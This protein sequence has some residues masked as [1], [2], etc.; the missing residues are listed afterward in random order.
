MKPTPILLLAGDTGWLPLLGAA[1]SNDA[2]GMPG[3]A[4]LGG[5]LDEGGFLPDA[6]AV[7]AALRDP[8]SVG[9]SLG[10]SVSV[11]IGLA[12]HRCFASSVS[13]SGLPTRQL[14]QT[15]AYRFE[16][17]VPFAVEDLVLDVHGR[18]DDRLVV[19]AHFQ[20]LQALVH[21]LEDAGVRVCGI[22][23]FALLA[24][25]S[26]DLDGSQDDNVSPI[27][28]H[29]LSEP[30]VLCTAKVRSTS[31]VALSRDGG[32]QAWRW[33]PG[34]ASDTSLASQAQ[35]DVQETLRLALA[36]TRRVVAEEE[37]LWINLQQGPLASR[38][39][40]DRV[41]RPL[42][43][44][45]AAA[46]LLMLASIGAIQAR[47]WQ[48]QNVAAEQDGQARALYA[49]AFPGEAVPVSM[50]RRLTTRL[51]GLRG[52]Q[53]LAITDTRLFDEENTLAILRDLL[54]RLPDN[55]RFIITD[56][57]LNGDRVDLDGLARSHSDADTLATALRRDGR[58]QV[59][60]PSTENLPTQGVRFSLNLVPQAQ[61]VATDRSPAAPLAAEQPVLDG[62]TP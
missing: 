22:A 14:R 53:G 1:F 24:A 34:T 23:P 50:E 12:S 11:V 57:R 45:L 38:H 8:S 25:Q 2:D 29:T 9:E 47:A 27:I 15:L 59:T 21:E 17:A 31:E 33:L 35:A 56:L 43:A 13:A 4:D 18:A 7:L 55:T 16:T 39:T 48:Y 60:P 46:V 62:R 44:L 5:A 3:S 58:F 54:S 41:R 26:V 37:A 10:T 52:R 19:A 42:T 40:L 28:T 32:L 61:P 51:R 6:A 30:A 49:S 20:P 36:T